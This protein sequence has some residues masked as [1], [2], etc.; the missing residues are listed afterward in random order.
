MEFVELLPVLMLFSLALLL[1]SGLPV[2]F[3][4]AGLGIVFSLIGVA[5]G[6]MPSGV[7]A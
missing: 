2:A 7:N 3:I 1:F 5:I 4:L 6:E